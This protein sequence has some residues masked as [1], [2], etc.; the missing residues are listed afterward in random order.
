MRTLGREFSLPGREAMI[1]G[2]Y[3]HASAIAS[4]T[5]T[6]TALKRDATIKVTFPASASVTWSVDGTEVTAA[7]GKNSVTPA[8][9]GITADGRTHT[10]T[11]KATD[12][13]KAV[14]DPAL[15][16]LLTDSRTWKVTA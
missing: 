11:A 13:T 15:R 7:R 3:Q 1:A 10:V 14:K 12:N 16:K 5:G 2:F 4:T 9:L 6:D 8:S